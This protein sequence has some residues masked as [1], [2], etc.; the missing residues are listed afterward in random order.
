MGQN[1]NYKANLN[2]F[3]MWKYILHLSL[4]EYKTL[5]NIIN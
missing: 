4:N 2:K 5:I 1:S 3:D